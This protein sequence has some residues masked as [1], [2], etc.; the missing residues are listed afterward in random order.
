MGVARA[1]VI[2]TDSAEAGGQLQALSTY[3]IQV[4]SDQGG[5]IVRSAF[6]FTLSVS[7]S[8]ANIGFDAVGE[9]IGSGVSTFAIYSDS[10]GLPASQLASVIVNAPT[11]SFRNFG[12][13]FS[14]LS[15]NAD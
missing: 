2:Y 14:A 11:D 6:P 10:G 8:A 3:L 7:V 12:G 9:Q 5:T 13:S 1:S 4:A 15:L